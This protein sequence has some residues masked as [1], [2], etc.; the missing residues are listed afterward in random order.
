LGAERV[1]TVEPVT[2]GETFRGPE[3][4]EFTAGPKC[5]ENVGAWYCA[6]CEEGFGNQLQKS[7]HVHAA[8]NTEHRLVWICR[9]HGP[10]VP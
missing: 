7:S 4:R 9:D 3:G 5:S 8:P 2:L 10:E 6:T 1:S